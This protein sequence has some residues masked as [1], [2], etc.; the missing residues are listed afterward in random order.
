MH[1]MHRRGV[2]V[3]A[4]RKTYGSKVKVS[5]AV[6]YKS[7]LIA[8]TG[9]FLDNPIMRVTFFTNSSNKTGYYSEAPSQRPSK[10]L[11]ISGFAGWMLIIRK[12]ESSIAASASK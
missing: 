1:F 12:W 10:S 8:D 4:A 9:T 2:S 3:R 7:G 11:S 6:T 5:T